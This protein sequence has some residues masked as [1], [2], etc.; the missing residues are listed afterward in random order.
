MTVWEGLQ[1][2]LGGKRACCRTRWIC[3]GLH[4]VSVPWVT[5]TKADELGAR[6]HVLELD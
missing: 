4:T 1:L 3:F 6:E 5:E 2:W